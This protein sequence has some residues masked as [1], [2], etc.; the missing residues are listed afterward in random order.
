[1]YILSASYMGKYQEASLRTKVGVTSRYTDAFVKV[2]K[3]KFLANKGLK[4]LG[5]YSQRHLKKGYIIGEFVGK[6]LTDAEA[7]AKQGDK[8]YLFDVRKKGRVMY[9]ID[10]SDPKTSS[11][12]RYPNA[13]DTEAQQNAAWKQY[14][15]KIYM[16]LTKNVPKGQEILTWYGRS[17]SHITGQ[18]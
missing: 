15:G 16:V 17:T 2:A 5:L 7:E 13:A 11:V 4:G 3:S 8:S 12:P 1:M 14:D 9:V 6:I 18:I 10:G